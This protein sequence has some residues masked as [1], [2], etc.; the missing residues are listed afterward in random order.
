MGNGIHDPK[1]FPEGE[2][3]AFG[4]LEHVELP[5]RLEHPVELL[6]SP[7][8]LRNRAEG[9]GGEHL[10]KG[11]RVK[12]KI[13]CVHLLQENDAVVFKRPLLRLFQHRGAD[14]DCGNPLLLGKKADFFTDPH[15]QEED[16]P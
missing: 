6:Q 16:V 3:I 7:D 10:I 15:C 2:M 13:F 12:G 8:G 4:V 11:F 5:S 1:Y 9:A 14:V